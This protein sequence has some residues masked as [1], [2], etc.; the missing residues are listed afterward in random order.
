MLFQGCVI[1]L[2]ILLKQSQARNETILGT[3]SSAEDLSFFWGQ[4]NRWTCV[5]QEELF[6]CKYRIILVQSY[7]IA[8]RPASNVTQG[9]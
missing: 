2:T 1:I 9:R 5:A 6:F 4:K 7:I 3:G 8:S